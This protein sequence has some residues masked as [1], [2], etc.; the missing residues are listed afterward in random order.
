MGEA[1]IIDREMFKGGLNDTPLAL[2]RQPHEFKTFK[3]ARLRKDWVIE[4]V[5][6][7]YKTKSAEQGT[8]NGII[9]DAT[10]TKVT[11]IGVPPARIPLLELDATN[12]SLYVKY[13]GSNYTTVNLTEGSYYTYTA[14]A[15][16]LQTAMNADANISGITVT[17][18]VSVAKKFR[19]ANASG[20]TIIVCWEHANSTLT[21]TDTKKAIWG[22]DF[23]VSIAN[24]G[25]ADSAYECDSEPPCLGDER[26][27]F[28]DNI[29]EDQDGTEVTLPDGATSIEVSP[30]RIAG[31]WFQDRFYMSN[32]V[33]NY[34]MR[35]KDLRE[36]MPEVPPAFI[37]NAGSHRT[38][39][40]HIYSSFSH[41]I[42][43][44]DAGAGDWFEIDGD[45][46][47]YYEAGIV[48]KVS[49]STGN[50]GTYTVWGKSYQSG[51]GRTRILAG[52]VPDATVDGNITFVYGDTL[53]LSNTQRTARLS[54][55]TYPGHATI[56]VSKDYSADYLTLYLSY[57]SLND[58][59]VNIYVEVDNKGYKKLIKSVPGEDLGTTETAI[60]IDD[61]M[62]FV[63][64]GSHT[65]ILVE[66]APL[67]PG[68]TISGTL[69][70]HGEDDSG[71]DNVYRV[72][73]DGVM[74]DET[75]EWK[76]EMRV[77]AA[78]SHA[79]NKWKY[80]ISMINEDGYESELSTHYSRWGAGTSNTVVLVIEFP[81]TNY[82]FD[83]LRVYR[84][85]QGG[86]V[87]RLI[88]EIPRDFT[89]TA[90]YCGVSDTLWAELTEADDRT[91]RRS[92]VP[93]K[94]SNA[95]DGRQWISGSDAIIMPDHT[96]AYSVADQYENHNLSDNVLVIG[97]E[98]SAIT[99]HG[100]TENYNAVF[101]RNMIA[102]IYRADPYEVR[103]AAVGRGT[104]S[105]H[106]IVPHPDMPLLFFQ[107]QTGHFSVFDGVDV[108]SI[109]E[110]RLDVLVGTMN[111]AAL[112]ATSG[113]CDKDRNE[114]V[115]NICTGSNTT[116]NKSI[117]YNMNFD[118]WE[119]PDDAY[120]DFYVEDN[121]VGTINS[122]NYEGE[123][124]YI[125]ASNLKV[126]Y[127]QLAIYDYNPS[128]AAED[129]IDLDIELADFNYETQEYKSFFGFGM[130]AYGTNATQTITATWYMDRSATSIG[131]NAFTMATS[132]A[133]HK[134]GMS[135]MGQWGRLRLQNDDKLGQV[136]VAWMRVQFNIIKA[137]TL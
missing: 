16:A 27:Y 76:G 35:N 1:Y 106:S 105:H 87:Y 39:D 98:G 12:K 112:S 53:S 5:A 44:V 120:A 49:G 74:T 14:L 19:I 23:S 46:T 43:G 17:F 109:S 10:A 66:M 2:S 41:A 38:H 7:R 118:R 116:P 62:I 86:S 55:N 77:T 121:V 104:V 63:P 101:K 107:D 54:L 9:Q 128:T 64:S 124:L 126:F 130:E 57:A 26:I 71:Q 59:T 122:V 4:K 34:I 67:Y 29:V 70:I 73:A 33:K 96:I 8:S 111:K 117:R 132:A 3:N 32:G 119:G 21:D 75:F 72:S 30:H 89:V 91:T 82:D 79:T 6:G 127:D 114:I 133:L 134:S 45:H 100:A 48:F 113:H 22:W 81:S 52:T 40:T 65:N 92:D 80:K 31:D 20:N 11:G 103:E 15:T 37:R 42:T 78:T 136:Y 28:T 125:G 85:A 61:R 95:W 56:K 60:T 58:F 94:R 83:Y 135:G 13:D 68:A 90:L 137:A 24:A 110:G 99:G 84:T 25:T 69:K 50:N 102:P 51:T 131:S 108:R 123:T 115:W 18:G 36:M 88:A 129:N 47:D 97:K 93:Y